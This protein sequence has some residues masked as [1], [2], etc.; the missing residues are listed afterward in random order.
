[1]LPE[2]TNLLVS[3]L[4]RTLQTASII[5]PEHP[6]AHVRELLVEGALDAKADHNTF[7]ADDGDEVLDLGTTGRQGY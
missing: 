4:Q 3:P 1:M 6:N 5:F 7:G 2:P